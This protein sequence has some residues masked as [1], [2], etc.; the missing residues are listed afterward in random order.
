[1]PALGFLGVAFDPITNS[2][3]GVDRVISAPGSLVGVA[4]VDAR[5]TSRYRAALSIDSRS[6]LTDQL[7][8]DT[9]DGDLG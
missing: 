2:V 3:R 6:L 5:E 4:V 7:N 8:A 9:K 1:M